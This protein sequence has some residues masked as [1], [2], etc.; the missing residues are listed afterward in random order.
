MSIQR[1]TST[2]FPAL[3]RWEY[4]VF[5]SFRGEDTRKGFTDNLYTALDDQGIKTFRDDPE[6]EKGEAIAPALSAA[7]EKSRFAVIVLSPNYAT[8]TWCLDE[9]VQILECMKAN[10][11]DASSSGRVLPIFYNVNPSDVRKQ[12]GS[13]KEAFCNLEKRFGIDGKEKVRRWRFALTEVANLSGR[14]LEECRYERELIRYI[15]E[16]ILKKLQFAAFSIAENLV[17]MESRLQPVFLHLGLGADDVRFIGIWG[18]GGIGKTTMV[19]EVYV[20]ISREFECSYLLTNVRDHSVEKDGLLNLQKQLL[21]GMISREKADNILNSQ[22][23]AA[24]IKRRLARKRVLLILDNVKQLKDLEYLAGSPNWFGSGSR[25]LITTRDE[26][27]L[28]QHEVERRLKVE[29]LDEGDSLK[30]F[31]K[32]AF[33]EDCPAEGFLD[34]SEY[35][36]SYANGLPLALEVLGSFLYGRDLSEWNSALSQLGEVCASEIFEVLKIS[37][38]DLNSHWRKIFLDIACFFDGHEKDKVTEVLNSCDVAAT[39]GIKVLMERSLVTLSYGRLCMH[40]L[41]REMGR[42]IVR[43]E[44]PDVLGKRSRL[45]LFEDVRH[46]LTTNTGTEEVEGIFVHST[47]PEGKVDVIPNSFSLMRKLRYLKIENANLP[48]GLEYLPNSIR[49]LCWTRYPLQSLPADFRP[50][51]LFEL[52]LCHSFLKHVQI[53]TEIFCKLKSINL[54]H[55]LNLVNTPN[56]KDMPYLEILC[57]QGCIRLCELDQGIEV[58]ERLTV[59]NLKDCKNL[60][61]FA[62]SVRGLKSLE[63]LDISGC[64][65]LKKLPN[66]MDHL[67][68]LKELCVNG[69][70]IREVPSSIGMLERLQLLRMED[71]KD[72]VSLPISVRGLKSL[73]VVNISGCLKLD[74]LPE[75][76]GHMECLVKV[77]ASETSI[78]ELPC[79]I[80]MLKGLFSMSLRDCKQL[81]CLPTSIGGLKSLKY[82]NLSGCLKLDRLPDELGHISSLEKLYMG[83]IGIREVPPSISLLKNLRVFSLAGYKAASFESWNMMLN[84]LQLL[85]KQ[86][87]IQ[88]GLSLSCLFGLHSLIKLDLSDCNLY[89]EAMPSDFGCL[90]SLKRLDLRNN[91]IVRLPESIGQLSRLEWLYLD[92]CSKLQIV[93][94]LSSDAWVNASNCTSLDIMANR[95]GRRSLLPR[96]RYINSLNKGENESCESVALTLLAR[97]FASKASYQTSRQLFT[98]PGNEIPEWYNHRGEGSS[99][100]I[101]LPLGWFTNSFMGFAMCVVFDSLNP[102][103]YLDWWA[104][105]WSMTAIGKSSSVYGQSQFPLFEKKWGQPVGDHIWFHYVSHDHFKGDFQ[106]IKYELKFSFEHNWETVRR[107]KCGVRVVYEEDAEKI[108]QTYL[109]QG[110]GNNTKRGL[111]PLCDDVASSSTAGL[112]HRLIQ[113]EL[114]CATLMVRNQWKP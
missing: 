63:V 60:V 94:E 34:L 74:K 54:S 111:Q 47:E 36:V 7:I 39:I 38:N 50:R 88:A 86:S 9:L 83:R 41:L 21:S 1:S 29:E 78:R 55:S 24:A 14:T 59:L 11:V 44:S 96:G 75:D 40:D 97:H 58:L 62:S 100:T 12:T 13:F 25:V 71:C 108:R 49:I 16:D 103:R 90:A 95:T 3:T 109:K 20:R 17:A 67:E 53:G 87:H 42:E 80:G 4:D 73:K 33:K 84:P 101:D 28:I 18:M 66:D 57:L 104:I 82:L 30:L 89:D 51:Q 46:I 68:S 48:N 72:L 92:G 79:S 110:M 64:S 85:R 22:D 31:S 43:L 6:L 8:S 70:G 56:L 35:V 77:D 106:D 69:S 19:T 98:G 107:K 114:N 113:K 5:I 65:K 81:S 45:W 91:Q 112:Q 102:P 32:K 105:D 26:H 10:P 37:Y 61:H 52:T 2:S 15:V 27:L 93:P 23:G 99:I 76:L